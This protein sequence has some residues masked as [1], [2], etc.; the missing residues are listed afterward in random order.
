MRLLL[1]TLALLIAFHTSAHAFE[2]V[3]ENKSYENDPFL[4]LNIGLGINQ[5]THTT[6]VEAGNPGMLFQV[7]FEHRLSPYLGVEAAY[8]LGTI[9]F[10]SPDPIAT[11]S[12]IHTRTGTQQEFL[13]LKAYYPAVVA[14]PY[15][16]AGFGSYQFF[17]TSGETALSLP[18]NWMIP[19][20]AGVQTYVMKDK[21]S[22]DFD[23]TYYWYF[24]ENQDATTLTILGLQKVSFNMLSVM[25]GFTFH[26]L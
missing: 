20:G 11:S 7:G 21:I 4:S 18:A 24:G 2:V 25:G 15:V 16:S 5:F 1:S 26:F 22:L 3:N 17:G 10:Y 14:K 19:F 6:G 23:F 12:L 13:R 9:R 8:Q